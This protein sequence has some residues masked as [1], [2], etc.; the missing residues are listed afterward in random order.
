MSQHHVD[1]S[2]K[3]ME[4]NEMEEELKASDVA[5]DIVSRWHTTVP[6][7]YDYELDNT[8]LQTLNQS[9][10]L[11]PLETLAENGDLFNDTDLQPPMCKQTPTLLLKSQFHRFANARQ[12]ESLFLPRRA[13]VLQSLSQIKT[14]TCNDS[15][16]D[17]SGL[18]SSS[19]K[20]NLEN[21]PSSSHKF[22]DV[23][24]NSF[25]QEF[26]PT[27]ER[28]T[29]DV[30]DEICCQKLE[31]LIYSSEGCAFRKRVLNQ[32][33][34]RR[35][36]PLRFHHCDAPSYIVDLQMD[37]QKEIRDSDA[38]WM[39]NNIGEVSNDPIAAIWTFNSTDAYRNGGVVDD[40]NKLHSDTYSY[41]GPPPGISL[42]AH[43]PS[44][45]HQN[46]DISSTES[47]TVTD[48][49]EERDVQQDSHDVSSEIPIAQS[50]VNAEPHATLDVAMATS[51]DTVDV[52][53]SPLYSLVIAA[54]VLGTSDH[55]R[56]PPISPTLCPSALPP[57]PSCTFTSA[58]NS[59]PT[60]PVREAAP[61][62]TVKSASSP[63]K[64]V[65]IDS[66]TSRWSPS[67]AVISSPS[68]TNDIV[69]FP[70]SSLRINLGEKNG[71]TDTNTVPI[72]SSASIEHTCVLTTAQAKFPATPTLA[73]TTH[74]SK[75]IKRPYGMIRTDGGENSGCPD[76]A[77]ERPP[78]LGI[79]D[80]VTQSVHKT[81]HVLHQ[82]APHAQLVIGVH[83]P[84]VTT[85]P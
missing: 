24:T 2:T 36:L 45:T 46:K 83:P 6:S 67:S 37:G 18:S 1:F 55:Q 52:T 82:S 16:L 53:S 8:H 51:T 57:F 73:G 4:Y 76:G 35:L 42:P 64:P 81:A 34:H 66:K 17:T 84:G 75:Q 13:F 30:I 20:E 72:R 49:D 5:P 74:V 79:G 59:P 68:H 10:P 65:D 14:V 63:V 71:Y 23:H 7:N 39:S 43:V 28:F 26:G 3:S 62:P 50:L 44:N 56:P 58:S 11:S 70:T 60:T 9:H 38:S 47:F 25:R 32:N 22:E 19:T 80:H 48:E 31:N 15:L 12:H 69:V 33:L 78:I 85:S 41:T 27:V 77:P 21:S 29:E 40:F 54:S 61:S